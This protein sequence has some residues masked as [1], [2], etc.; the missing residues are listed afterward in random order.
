MCKHLLSISIIVLF[1][2]QGSSQVI[3]Q[4]TAL[5]RI[6]ISKQDTLY[7][8]Y[9]KNVAKEVKVIKGKNYY[10]YYRDTILITKEGYD[11]RLL[12][13]LYTVYYPNKNLKEQGNFINGLKDGEWKFWYPN[14]E[15]ASVE[16]WKKGE[17]QKNKV[18]IKKRKKS[19][20]QRS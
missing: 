12:E 14:G 9:A 5:N 3:N 7:T 13:G 15:L 10:W 4:I 6:N 19:N 2:F 18:K 11:G 17:L 16:K 8:F 20:K 1:F